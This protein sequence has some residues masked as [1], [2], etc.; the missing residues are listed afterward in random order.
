MTIKF[1]PVEHNQSNKKSTLEFILHENQDAKTKQVTAEV[2]G[3]PTKCNA[4][5]RKDFDENCPE[6]IIAKHKKED[7]K[8]EGSW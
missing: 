5:S 3:L 1:L 8:Y 6:E 4:M 2:E 7:G